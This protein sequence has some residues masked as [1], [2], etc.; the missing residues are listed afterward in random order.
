[1]PFDSEY[2]LMATFHELEDNGRKVIRCF[3]KGA[4][5]V[6]LARSSQV[7]DVDGSNVPTEEGRDRVLAENDR[8]AGQG[9]RVLAVASRDIDP[10]AFDPDGTLLDEVQGLTLLA[11][12][13]IVDPRKEARMR[14]PL[15]TAGSARAITGDHVTTAPRSGELRSR[16]DVGTEVPPSATRSKR[17]SRRSARRTRRPR[18]EVRL[19]D[20]Q[21]WATSSRDRG[22]CQRRAGA[23]ARGHRRRDGDRSTES[24]RKPGMISGRQLRDHRARSAARHLR[25][26]DEVRRIGVQLVRSTCSSAPGFSTSPTGAPRLAADPLG[27]LR[28][29]SCLRSAWARRGRAGPDAAPAEKTRTRRRQS[30]ACGRLG[31][32]GLVMAALALGVV[33]WGEHR[34]DPD[35]DDVG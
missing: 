24:R 35:R 25:Q 30:V 19:V 31:F 17:R 1:V 11:L 2:K 29:T 15:Q 5:D 20:A 14:S 18:T 34:Y 23:Q 9:L 13:A 27:Q 21:A 22:R 26:P 28:S 12:V 7:R 8:L 16:G 10:A 33:A 3:V 32:L 4:P 6:L